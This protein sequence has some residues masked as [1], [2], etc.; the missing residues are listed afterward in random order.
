VAML[1]FLGLAL[2]GC[3]TMIADRM[4]IR[5]PSQ[6]AGAPLSTAELLTASRDA[7]MD[8][9]FAEADITSLGDTLHWTNPKRPPGLHIMV[10]RAGDDVRVTLAQ[11][12]FGPIGPTDGYRC[13]RKTLRRRLEERCGKDRVRLES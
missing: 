1:V 3:D 6:A 8:C 10:H 13:V 9:R 12:L 7:L 5:A 2:S 4:I 11:D